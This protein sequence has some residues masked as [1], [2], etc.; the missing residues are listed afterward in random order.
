MTLTVIHAYRFAL[1]PTPRQVGALVRHCGA[2]RVAFN[3][4]LALVK[5]N[6]AQRA[7]ER[8]YAI[9]EEALTP[10]VSWSMYSLRK[11]WNTV[12]AEVAPW[13][14]ECSKEAYATGFDQLA[15]ALRT[16]SDSKR[17]KRR[18]PRVGFPRFKSKRK[19]NSSCRF[20]TGAIRLEPDRK[21]VTLPMLGTIKTHESTRKL[22]RRITDGTARIISARVRREAGRWFCSFTVEVQRSVS[23]PRRPK[24]VIGVDLGV[25]T[26]AVF[27]DGR[28][29]VENP[30]HYDTARRRLARLSRT[31]SRRHGPDRRTGTRPSKRWERANLRRNRVHHRIGNL[32]RDAIHK[33]TTSL[34]REYGIVVVEDLNVAG[35]VG[36][37]RLARALAD[38]GFGE[39]RRQLVYKTIW[40]GGC[41]TVADRW[42]PSSKTCSG[43]QAV[44]PKLPL[45]VRTYLCEH[46][47]LV[48]DR[49]VNAARNLAALVKRHVAG[50]GPETRNGCGADRQTKPGLAGGCEASTPLRAVPAWARR[51]PSPSNGRIMESH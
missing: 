29:P 44:K 35:M 11:R 12:K 15:H 32:R 5:A 46:C 47:G 34:A 33:L 40:H 28:A 25:K 51:G 45:R 38:A 26:L 8:S 19:A 49:D 16:W 30:R 50:S 1:D 48:L 3:W 17:G 18:G 21:H 7:A 42:F 24:T 2:A 10:P 23:A 37:R 22:H 6:L 27:S 20:T 13:W 31:V 36:N 43:C 14:A 39:I 41:L 4:G 9:T